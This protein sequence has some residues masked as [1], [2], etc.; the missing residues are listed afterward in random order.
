V[1]WVDG[2]GEGR[3]EGGDG[4]GKG[5]RMKKDRREKGNTRSEVKALKEGRET[6]GSS[7]WR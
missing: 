4:G 6:S 5:N 2:G 1:A 3:G 7:R